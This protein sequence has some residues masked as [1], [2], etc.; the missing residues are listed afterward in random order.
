MYK[1]SLVKV[2]NDLVTKDID[3]FV[4]T[5]MAAVE[6][7]LVE[8]NKHLAGYDYDARPVGEGTYLLTVDRI[9]L[10][11]FVITEVH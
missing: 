8:C 2:G 9:L 11:S 7:A 5:R 10:G 3:L 6:A 4:G 1:L